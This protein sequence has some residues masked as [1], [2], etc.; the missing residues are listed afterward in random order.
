MDNLTFMQ[1]VASGDRSVQ[2]LR[3][4][5]SMHKQAYN[6]AAEAIAGDSGEDISEVARY[7]AGLGGGS[8]NQEAPIAAAP[9]VS[10]SGS[11][12]AWDVTDKVV[13]YGSRLAGGYGGWRGG[14]RLG[15]V[16]GK[17][18]GGA[19]TRGSAAAG[20]AVGDR[21][22]VLGGRLGRTLGGVK[23]TA[24]NFWALH[25]ELA[26]KIAPNTKFDLGGGTTV[27]AGPNP[28]RGPGIE[29]MPGMQNAVRNHAKK[30]VSGAKLTPGKQ[31]AAKG[32]A[33]GTKITSGGAKLGKGISA[34]GKPVLG[35]AGALGGALGA[36]YVADKAMDW[37]NPYKGEGVAH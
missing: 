28:S 14:S 16:L 17:S 31:M 37:I 29:G 15:D 24:K 7:L 13:R 3:N 36:G 1:K 30:V 5:I 27:Y 34:V 32:R 21:L 23:A 6:S 12:P 2:V 11:H 20:K 19:V 26:A 9:S 18:L 35:A 33:V 22:G 25:P 4:L 8:N 10:G